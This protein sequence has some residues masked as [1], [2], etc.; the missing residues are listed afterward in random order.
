MRRVVLLHIA[1]DSLRKADSSTVLSF[2][3]TIRIGM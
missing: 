3:V 2:I 1:I